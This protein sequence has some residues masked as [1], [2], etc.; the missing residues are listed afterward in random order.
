[1]AREITVGSDGRAR[2]VIHFDSKGEQQETFARVIVVAGNAIETPRLL[3]LSR[4]PLFPD[5]LANSSGLI[6]KRLMEHLSVFAYG[7]FSDRVDPWRGVPTGGIIQDFYATDPKNNF[8]RGCTIS[9]EMEPQWPWATAWTIPGWG[10]EHKERMKEVFGHRIGLA[11]DGEQ[12]PDVR[13]HVMLD[14]GVQDNFGLP[15]PLIVTE[16]SSNDLAMVKAISARLKE[17]LEA[18]GARETWVEKFTPGYSSHY[19]GTCTMGE[20][21]KIS[22][23]DP[24]CRTHDVPNLY[25]GD[26]SVFVTVAAVNPALT[27]SALATRTAEGI[28]A[29][30]RHGEFP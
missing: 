21:P 20:D 23:V 15:V 19:L 10:F 18:A 8:V 4:S 22:V 2:S 1:M 16:N 14:P 7:V 6:G 11:S 5:G 17:I 28:I 12:L 26:G 24:W 30:F 29:A 13:N 25:I 9:V 3:L 27:I